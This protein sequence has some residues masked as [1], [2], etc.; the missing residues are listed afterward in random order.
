MQENDV[1]R[2]LVQLQAAMREKTERAACLE[3]QFQEQG[4][5]TAEREHQL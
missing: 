5:Q 3:Q 4:E 1:E 2:Q